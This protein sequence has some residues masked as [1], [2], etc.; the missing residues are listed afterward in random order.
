MNG[1]AI[2]IIEKV[3]M[4]MLSNRPIGLLDSGIG[5]LTVLKEAKK[6]LPNESFVYIGDSARNPYG[7]RTK[8]EIADYTNELVQFL[9]N[10][11]VKM[12]VIACNTATAVTL[13]QLR[14]KLTIPVLGV[15]SAG[16]K[17]AIK[18]SQT[19]QV[20]VL[21]TQ[22]TV[23]SKFYTK[24]IQSDAPDIKIKSLACPEFVELVESNQ[25]STP[26][27]ELVVAKKLAPLKNQNIDTLILGC[28]HFPLLADFIQKELGESVQLIDSGALTVNYIKETLNEL[29][30]KAH[31]SSDK[32]F[33]KIYTTGELPLFKEI[34]QKWMES[35]SLEFEHIKLKG[36]IEIESK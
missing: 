21:A 19:R 10:Q 11:N 25:Y 4:Y 30:M 24:T 35:G 22:S 9:L 29:D 20:G 32:S 36:L 23:K 6:M 16:S 18:L 27:A 1:L 8:D 12:I 3:V 14:E 33:T 7:N 34:A 26:Y 28:T 31:Y 5:G 13:E 17:E 2:C 15:I